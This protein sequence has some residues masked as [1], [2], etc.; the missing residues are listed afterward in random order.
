MDKP[1]LF[2]IIKSKPSIS[3]KS[4]WMLEIPDVFK[5]NACDFYL[6]AFKN[7]YVFTKAIETSLVDESF[8]I[9][10]LDIKI[11]FES[12]RYSL[13]RLIKLKRV[14]LPSH[15]TT[16][17]L[18]TSSKKEQIQLLKDRA[19]SSNELTALIVQ[20]AKYGYRFTQFKVQHLP[21]DAKEEDLPFVFYFD[22]DSIDIVGLNK[23]PIKKLSNF[24][25]HRKVHIVKFIENGDRWFCFFTTY[26][27][28]AGQETGN[29]KGVPHLHLI[30]NYWGLSKEN[31]F[32][33]LKGKRY[34]VPSIHIKLDR[35]AIDF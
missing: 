31:V 5:V 35:N 17:L 20:S 14:V 4:Y 26:N 13:D 23:Y 22:K 1:A 19:I 21:A 15:L 30:T 18:H 16:L 25:A 3:G 28:I 9:D 12:V 34:K 11:K 2:K 8:N 10:K 24:I 6:N 33:E 27:A 29:F 32:Q 7:H